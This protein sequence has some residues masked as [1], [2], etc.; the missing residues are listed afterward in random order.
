VQDRTRIALPLLVLYSSRMQSDLPPP[1]PTDPPP[2]AY[3]KFAR[4]VFV[5]CLIALCLWVLQGFLP[6]L[7]WALVIAIAT[8]P[9]RER[10]VRAGLNPTGAALLLTVAF[11]LVLVLPVVLFGAELAR[12]ARGLTEIFDQA[13][14]GELQPPDWLRQLPFVGQYA[15]AWWLA[16]LGTPANA[17]QLP[18]G[19]APTAVEFGRDVGR[20][21]VRRLVIFGFTLLTLL[22]L[23]KD[24]ARLAADLE[25]IGVRIFGPSAR[26]YGAFSIRALQ[27]TVNGL[28]L[29]GFA[30]GALLGVGY[31]LAGV[32]HPIGFAIVTGVLG[33][34]PFG[35]PAVVT[36]AA[37]T[38]IVGGQPA[39]G[40]A[41]LILGWIAIV[42]IDHTAR[43][44]LIG[45][46]IRLPFFWAL[47]GVFGGLE[48]FGLV[49]L[50]LGPAILAVALAIWREA[51]GHAAPETR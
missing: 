6:A 12:E 3:A 15:A 11:G 26:T 24:G 31:A 45:N 10:L 28:I 51:I 47:L 44:A 46:A 27:G 30:E 40:L 29:V 13:R 37:F 33:I 48:A 32:T 5:A 14:R 39:A 35:A 38:L 25:R 22:F 1:I 49:G 41:L 16:H 18:V 2:F 7:V 34:I 42:I 17:P 50:F 20:F 43:P 19:Q 4:G 36:I 9:A 8:W 21:V 23:Y